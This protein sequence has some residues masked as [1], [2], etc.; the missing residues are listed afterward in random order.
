[1]RFESKEELRNYLSELN[2]KA[3]QLSPF[4][5]KKSIRFGLCDNKLRILN[6]NWKK[7]EALKQTLRG[8]MGP[9]LVNVKY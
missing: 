7:G 4:G 3:D 2:K 9:D 8:M 1:M 5:F 6:T